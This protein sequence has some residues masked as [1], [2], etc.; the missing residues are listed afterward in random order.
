M[1]L[2][3]AQRIVESWRAQGLKVALANGVFDLLH[4]DS[5]P[6]EAVFDQFAQGS[7]EGGEFPGD[8]H[9]HLA[10][11]VV[12]RAKLDRERLITCGRS[13]RSKARHASKHERS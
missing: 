10:E 5:S 12:D 3:E 7:F 6:G 2:E 11:L 8:P 9:L 13:T 4:V 1:N